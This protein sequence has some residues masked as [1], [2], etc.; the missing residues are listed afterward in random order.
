MSLFASFHFSKCLQMELQHVSA[1]LLSAAAVSCLTSIVLLL[2]NNNN[3][4]EPK[5]TKR[6]TPRK[7]RIPNLQRNRSV[8]DRE[9]LKTLPEAVFSSGMRMPR[10]LFEQ[11]LE[12]IV[13]VMA[14]KMH[15]QRKLPR[16]SEDHERHVDP[17]VALAFTLRWL[18]GAQRWDLMFMFNVAKSTLHVWT[19]RVIHAIIYV[20]RENILFPKDEPSLD[21]LAAGF[22]N[23]AGGLGAAIP[24]TVCA[25]DGVVIPATSPRQNNYKT[26]S[27]VRQHT[28]Q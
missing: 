4:K 8:T 28:M 18:A 15:R 11:L 12:K 7:V 6:G 21:A 14:S 3:K 26:N 20:L 22:A 19:W 24:H 13:P 27:P 23:I 9:K 25:F 2:L 1:L 17:Y 16:N 10:S 5:L